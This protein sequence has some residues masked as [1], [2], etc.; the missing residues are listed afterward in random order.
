MADGDY[1]GQDEALG[2]DTQNER[3]LTVRELTWPMRSTVQ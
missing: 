3:I 2:R 1:L